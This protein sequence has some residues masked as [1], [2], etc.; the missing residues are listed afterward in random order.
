MCILTFV[1][2]QLDYSIVEVNDDKMIDYDIQPM[3]LSQPADIKS[4]DQVYVIQHPRGG[5]L[6]FS[7]SESIV[8]SEYMCIF[9]CV[10]ACVCV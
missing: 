3:H 9:V 7:S 2:T 10:C 8:Q 1:H 5:S 4:G 6:A